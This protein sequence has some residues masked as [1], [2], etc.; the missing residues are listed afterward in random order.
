MKIRRL[1]IPLTKI[2][3][4]SS[5]FSRSVPDYNDFY[6]VYCFSAKQ[7]LGKTYGVVRW[8]HGFFND[9]KIKVYANIRTLKE[10]KYIYCNDMDT[11]LQ[12]REKN[13]VFFIDEIFKKIDPNNKKQIAV[14]TQ[15]LGQSRKHRRVVIFTTQE[16]LDLPIA[17]RRFCRRSISIQK[18]PFNYRIMRWGDAE[19]MIYDQETSEYTCPIVSTEIIRISKK[20][21]NLYDTLEA[22]E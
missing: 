3:L 4:D 8:L 20:I 9:K 11:I 6:G 5:I 2:Y 12:N 7:G 17:L 13:V 15:W 22:V 16:W 1:K 18:L 10:F 19:N 21:T 14:L